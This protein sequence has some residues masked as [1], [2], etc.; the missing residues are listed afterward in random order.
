M[1]VNVLSLYLIQF[2]LSSA[3]LGMLKSAEEVLGS[4][5][6]IVESGLITCGEQVRATE[7]IKQIYISVSG[8]RTW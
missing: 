8:K 1:A 4:V 3:S 7:L 5:L 2:E 6:S